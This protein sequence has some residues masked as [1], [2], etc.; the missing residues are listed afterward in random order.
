MIAI[1][2]GGWWIGQHGISQKYAE[3]F[4]ISLII[5]SGAAMLV[6]MKGQ[7]RKEKH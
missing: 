6:I 7:S 3:I 2:D 5:E 4:K 1:V